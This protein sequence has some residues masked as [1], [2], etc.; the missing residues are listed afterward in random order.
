[1]FGCLSFYVVRTRSLEVDASH[2]HR[3]CWVMGHHLCIAQQA[4]GSRFRV[5][6]LAAQTPVSQMSN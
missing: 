2:L 1:M 4:L 6:A 3:V 5:L